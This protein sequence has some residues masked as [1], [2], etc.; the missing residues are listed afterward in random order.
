MGGLHVQCVCTR[1]GGA[2]P[3]TSWCPMDDNAP[4]SQNPPHLPT[5]LR[6]SLNGALHVDGVPVPRVPVPDAGDAAQRL[7]DLP[8][9]VLHLP[10]AYQLRVGVPCVDLNG[11]WRDCRSQVERV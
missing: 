6:V 10:V 3:L 4:P 11:R 1:G 7:G 9:A 2:H 8:R 5:Y